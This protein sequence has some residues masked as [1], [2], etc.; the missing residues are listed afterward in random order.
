MGLPVIVDADTRLQMNGTPPRSYEFP[1]STTPIKCQALQF[2]KFR[3]RFIEDPNF[4]QT[5][6]I[7]VSRMT[8]ARRTVEFTG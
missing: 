1:I 6:S 3:R 4:T 7:K 2:T 5:S 8:C